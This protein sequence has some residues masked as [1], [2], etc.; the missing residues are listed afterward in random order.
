[1][2]NKTLPDTKSAMRLVVITGI[3]TSA[4]LLPE[5]VTKI[6]NLEITYL[7]YGFISIF[8]TNNVYAQFKN[9]FKEIL[10]G[11][12]NISII[13]W[14]LGGV[15]VKRYLV[16][17]NQPELLKRIKLIILV[18]A[19]S[20]SPGFYSRLINFGIRGLSQLNGLY[21]SAQDY[22]NK[23]SKI[24]QDYRLNVYTIVGAYDKV[25]SITSSQQS[26]PNRVF[27]VDEDHLSLQLPKP[28]SMTSRVL[29]KLVMENL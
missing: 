5:E 23:W 15:L 11:N 24:V 25:A 21:P 4:E 10:D 19:P 1:M 13:A 6:P 2:D 9:Y 28:E 22:E 16:E 18:G 12:E 3:R 20:G 27:V 29:E 8:S 7:R 14:S 26:N 17:N